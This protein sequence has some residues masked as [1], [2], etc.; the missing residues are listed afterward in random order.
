MALLTAASLTRHY[1]GPAEVIR[2]VDTID[3]SMEAGELLVLRGTSGAGKSTLLRLL[4]GLEPADSGTVLVG[5][6][7]VTAMSSD[8][9]ASL[10]AHDIGVVF[11]DNNL[12]PE[13]SAIENVMLPL[14]L[15][16]DRGAQVRE[17]AAAW[18][19]RVGLAGLEDRAPD[20]LSGGQQQRVGIARALIGGRSILLADEPTGSLDS[21]NAGAIFRT[22]RELADHGVL[23]VISTHDP[24]AVDFAD[25]VVSMRDG[26]IAEDSA[27][28]LV[29]MGAA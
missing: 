6:R 2:A 27:T 23:V 24:F 5:G 1:V 13:F 19:D 21:T 4:A 9:A 20:Q 25:R 26:C 28:A 12:V 8:E 11:Q 17:E 3:L 29:G 10:R 15:R 18:L 14:E 22:L 7:D 16:G